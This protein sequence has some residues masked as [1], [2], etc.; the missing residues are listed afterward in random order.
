MAPPPNWRNSCGQPVG[1]YPK[2]LRPSTTIILL[3][4]TMENREVLCQKRA[5][6]G[7]W[8]FPGGSQNIGESISQCAVREALEETGLEVTLLGVTSIDSDPDHYA[9]CSYPDGV[10][11]YT[12]I[13]FLATPAH[14]AL[15][16][17]VKVCEES[18][19]LKWVPVHQLPEPFLFNH[20]WRFDKALRHRGPFLPVG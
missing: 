6:N 14:I 16:R 15:A 8:G 19:A 12:N 5:D 11:Q 10:V 4:G 9:L 1:A 2:E 17:E 3:M 13:T 20:R 7:W 18:L